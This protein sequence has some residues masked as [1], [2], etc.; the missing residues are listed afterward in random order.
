MN[1]L[2]R[3]KAGQFR[4]IQFN[5][6]L[7]DSL[8]H[9]TGN[10]IRLKPRERP[11][12]HWDEKLTLEFNGPAPAVSSIHIEPLREATTVFLAGNSTV[13]DQAEE[14]YAAWG[15]IIPLFSN[16]IES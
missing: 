13:V 2:I 10:K 15:Q 14:P 12:F 9:A 11:Y 16:P 3:C 6:H 1:A 7:R 4:T 8:I 5:V